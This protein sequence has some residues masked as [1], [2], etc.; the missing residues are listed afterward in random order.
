M[1][2]EVGDEFKRIIFR[3]KQKLM[4]PGGG[5]F[6]AGKCE[7]DAISIHIENSQKLGAAVGDIRLRLVLGDRWISSRPCRDWMFRMGMPATL[8]AGRLLTAVTNFYREQ[9]EIGMAA[10][11]DGHRGGFKFKMAFKDSAPEIELLI[12]RF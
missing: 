7:R 8:S 6:T 12:D 10:C 3:R 4:R 1:E 11:P 9:I 2:R 5:E